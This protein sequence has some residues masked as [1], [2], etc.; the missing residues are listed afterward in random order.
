MLEKQSKRKIVFTWDDNCCRHYQYIGPLF[1]KY[2]MH[3]SFYVNPGWKNFNKRYLNGYRKLDSNG[4]EIGSHGYMH[5]HMMALT[6]E[7]Y[8]NQLVMSQQ[9]LQGWLGHQITT[10]AF[11][12]HEYSEEMLELARKYY[13]ETRN[14]VQNSVRYSLK[15]HTTLTD[16]EKIEYQTK[17]NNQ[18]L[19]FSGHSVA[20]DSKEILS[21]SRN[22]GYEPVLLSFLEDIIQLLLSNNAQSDFCT[23]S[24]LVTTNTGDL[25]DERNF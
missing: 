11:P 13:V 9:L 14:T 25:T 16:I 23:L 1:E 18:A 8:E 4:F 24:E 19:I 3:C 5:K 6:K 10:F 7:E 17:I 22:A 20:T 21:H 2:G 12:H 15:S